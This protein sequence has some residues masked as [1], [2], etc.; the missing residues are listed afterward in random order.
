MKQVYFRLLEGV[1]TGVGPDELKDPENQQFLASL[2]D[3]A[4]EIYA[5]ESV[6]LRVAKLHESGGEEARIVRADLAS[7]VRERST[8]RVRSEART[9]L[10]EL[11]GEHD[12]TVGAKLLAEIDAL[13]PPPR[14]LVEARTRVTEWLVAHDGLLPGE[15]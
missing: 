4:M 14:A 12:G 7:L 2:A 8:E 1:V 11:H 10:G 3:V 13:L 9:V 15:A 6:A 5:A